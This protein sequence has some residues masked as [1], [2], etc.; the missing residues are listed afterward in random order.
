MIITIV[1]TLALLIFAACGVIYIMQ[2]LALR[3]SVQSHEQRVR[4]RFKDA[5]KATTARQAVAEMRDEINFSGKDEHKTI[6]G[7]Q[8]RSTTETTPVTDGYV[9][10][11]DYSREVKTAHASPSEV[12]QQQTAQT[13]A[14]PAPQAQ[15]ASDG[16]YFTASSVA[17]DLEHA[18]G[19]EAAVPSLTQPEHA[20]ASATRTTAESA[21]ATTPA[22]AETLTLQPHL[23]PGDFVVGSAELHSPLADQTYQAQVE[24]Q[25]VCNQDLN[26]ASKLGQVDSCG[27]VPQLQNSFVPFKVAEAS[28]V[29]NFANSNCLSDAD[30]AYYEEL[31]TRVNNFLKEVN[32][33]QNTM[34]ESDMMTYIMIKVTNLASLLIA[35][36]LYLGQHREELKKAKQN[37][38]FFANIHFGTLAS[39]YYPLFAQQIVSCVADITSATDEEMI[40]AKQNML[41]RNII[42]ALVE[43]KPFIS[44]QKNWFK[45][46]DLL[47]F[48]TFF[49]A[50]T[51]NFD[52]R[53]PLER[54]RLSQPLNLFQAI[55][56]VLEISHDTLDV[57]IYDQF[58]LMFKDFQE[59]KNFLEA[60]LNNQFMIFNNLVRNFG[61]ILHSTKSFHPEDIDK[62]RARTLINESIIFNALP[63]FATEQYLNEVYENFEQAISLDEPVD[64]LQ[65]RIFYNSETLLQEVFS[66]PLCYIKAEDFYKMLVSLVI[67]Y[68]KV[69][70]RS[71]LF[72]HN[73]MDR[74]YD[75]LIYQGNSL[76]LDK[77]F[78]NDVVLYM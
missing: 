39:E 63:E 41:E 3:K 36:S 18:V 8:A 15:P 20:T 45:S 46:K 74:T 62:E 43:I 30:K 4:Q 44:N 65:N 10:V 72:E 23:R 40:I 50:H 6:L 27:F 64:V 71:E 66:S 13:T 17:D 53:N 54:A 5:S 56:R 58:S 75:S 21:P 2:R 16:S 7:N 51:V 73:K 52:N 57:I 42:C 47:R 22:T 67:A 49:Y 33:E 29:N 25:T 9:T 34:H 59:H 76:G 1:V 12:E 48:V 61:Y 32:D 14:T 24:G 55:A 19:M 31:Q 11:N 78:I 37:F 68:T 26:N 69:N 28:Y 77:D 38:P 70:F 35:Y 60:R